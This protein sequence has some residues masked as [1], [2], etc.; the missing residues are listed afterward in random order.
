MKL[1]PAKVM[2]A[3]YLS[4]AGFALCLRVLFRPPDEAAW[5]GAYGL[6][7][8]WLLTLPWSVALTVFAWGLIHD[9]THPVFLLYFALSALGNACLIHRALN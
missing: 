9:S 5:V 3:L 8:I 2:A 4:A 7:A 6:A 1:S